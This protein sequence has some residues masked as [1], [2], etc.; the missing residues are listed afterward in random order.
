MKGLHIF[1]KFMYVINIIVAMLLLFACILPLLPPK[2][3]SVLS[4]LNL[5]ISFLVLVNALFLLY[6]LAKLKKQLLLSL[7][8]LIIGYLSFGSVYKFSASKHVDHPDNIKVM[9]YNVRLFDLYE[10]LP[11]P[12]TETKIVDFIKKSAPD[13]LCIQ[14]YHPH[15]NVDFSFFKYKFEMLSGYKMKYGQAIFSQY[16]IINSGSIDFPDTDNNA[17]FADIVKGKDTVRLYNVHLES[18]KIDTNVESLKQEKSERLFKRVGG[19]FK[20]QQLQSELFV[21]HKESSP[22]KII[23]SGDFNN[24]DFSYV[25]RKIKGDLIDTFKDAGNGFGRTYDFRF[26]PVRIDFILVDDAFDVN[27]FKTFDVHYSDHYPIMA[28]LRLE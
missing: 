23:I 25:Y 7:I 12:N 17:I 18:M 20:M 27:G 15:K 3:F 9:N 11:D 24:T 22:Y 28:T 16:P 4:V 13:M 26:L 19:A 2:T 21:M 6:W 5:G 10:W 1:D 14:E 8:I